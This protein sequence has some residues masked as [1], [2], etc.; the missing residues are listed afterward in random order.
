MGNINNAIEQRRINKLDF[1]FLKDTWYVETNGQQHLEARAIEHDKYRDR[2]LEEQGWTGVR[3]SAKDLFR[4]L[5]ENQ[6]EQL[7]VTP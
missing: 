5:F 7:N 2:W 1:A 3:I 6:E 4:L